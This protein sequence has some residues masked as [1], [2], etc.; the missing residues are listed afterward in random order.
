[1][2]MP[3]PGRRRPLLAVRAIRRRTGRLL[4]AALVVAGVASASACSLAGSASPPKEPK[5]GGTLYVYMQADFEMLDPQRSYSANEAD[6][7][8]LLDRTLTT[9]KSAPGSGASEIV[10]DLA[11]DAG[12]PSENDTV[13]T[14][15]LRPG[16]RWQDG[17]PVTCSQV[18]YGVERRFTRDAEM[19][20]GP[21]YPIDYLQD[22]PDS[23]YLGPWV[24]NDNHGVG[25]QSIKCIDEHTIQFHLKRPVG[26]FGYTVAMAVF[27]PVPP[28]QDTKQ[29][30]SRMPFANGPYKIESHD[31]TQMTLVRN[32]FW[33]PKTDPVRKALPD[34]I[35]FRFKLDDNGVVTN[36]LIEDQGEA[37]N[38]IALDFNVAPNFLQQVENDPDLLARTVSGSSGAVRYMA[39]NTKTEPNPVCRQALEYAF[40]KRKYR[41]VAGGAALGDYATTMITP[42]LKAYKDFD[43]FASRSHPEGDPDQAIKLMDSQAKT[44]Q[45]CRTTITV[46]F[47]NTVQRRRLMSTVVEA[48]QRAGIQVNLAPLDPGSYYDTGI[49]DPANNFDMMLAGWVPDWANGSAIIPPLFAGSAIPALDPITGHASGNVNFSMLNDKKINDEILQALSETTPQ[50]QW[51]A[52]GDLDLQIQQLAVTIPILYE[53]QLSMVG[54][55]VLG[56]FIHPAFG[57]PDLNTIGLADPTLN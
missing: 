13:W 40:N 44:A 56:G 32:N 20:G 38:A 23:P 27:A 14:F 48:Y 10:G 22:N 21:Y 8:R 16:V 53:K 33:D 43:V 34:K 28:E 57:L 42:N 39:I 3:M 55:N 45:P 47:A 11:T 35:V 46:A 37:R 17:S 49:G 30:Y 1:M 18:R 25:L 9:Y 15:D 54:S 41:T 4:A 24:A 29:K 50:R 26:D 5:A 12:H 36:Q 31:D 52:W 19:S 7:L 51:T 2:Q 6:V